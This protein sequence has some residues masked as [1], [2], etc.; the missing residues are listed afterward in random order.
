MIEGATFDAR[1][2]AALYRFV[3]RTTADSL[4]LIYRCDCPGPLISSTVLLSH[5]LSR[6]SMCRATRDGP[7]YDDFLRCVGDTMGLVFV[8]HKDKY[9]F[10]ASISAGIQLPDDPKGENR[11]E[12]DVWHF[13]LSGH[14]IKGPTRVEESGKGAVWVA[15][16]EGGCEFLC[17]GCEGGAA[18][19]MR[20]CRQYIPSCRQLIHRCFAREGYV[21]A[22]DKDG[23][24]V[25]GG[26]EFF[27]ADEVEV[28]TA[29]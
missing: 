2:S 4:K 20:S 3:G 24:A 16:R 28:L 9:V 15:G 14:F 27:M 22:K 21:G 25:F 13:S 8:I 7:S 12:C 17:L 10:G 6:L 26:S 23:S 11:Y 29:V 19:D 1:Q 5:S 18:N